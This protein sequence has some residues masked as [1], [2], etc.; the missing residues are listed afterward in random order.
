M[1]APSS[2]GA[3]IVDSGAPAPR[4]MPFSARIPPTTE[5]RAQARVARAA[6]RAAWPPVRQPMGEDVPYLKGLLRAR[7]LTHIPEA[8]PASVPRLR[9]LLRR[10]GITQGEAEETVG[11]SLAELIERNKGIALWWLVATTLEASA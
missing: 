6:Q 7:G 2:D 9:Q 10:A 3:A 11:L 8:E 5:Q 1:T 4:E